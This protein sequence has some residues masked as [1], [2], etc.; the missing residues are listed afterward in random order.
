MRLVAEGRDNR[1]HQDQRREGHKK[2]DESHEQKIEGAAEV[3]AR[4]PQDEARRRPD[5]GA[6]NADKQ[7]GSRADDAAQD[8]AP[9]PVGAEPLRSG[10]REIS[11]SCF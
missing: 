7:R 4:Q 3:T 2:I 5:E 10:L 1:H 8:V 6:E 11:R 9:E